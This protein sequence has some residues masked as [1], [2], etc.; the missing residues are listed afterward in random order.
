MGFAVD[1]AE[2]KEFLKKF[3]GKLRFSDVIELFSAKQVEYADILS[4][5]PSSSVFKAARGTVKA[6]LFK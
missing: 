5:R 2:L 6:S 1:A 4:R 3:G